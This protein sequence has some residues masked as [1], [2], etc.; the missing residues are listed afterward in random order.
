MGAAL[1]TIVC[2]LGYWLWQD[3]REVADILKRQR[4]WREAQSTDGMQ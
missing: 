1:V 4:Q 3:T 2:L